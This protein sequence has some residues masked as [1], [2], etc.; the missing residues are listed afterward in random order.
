M[1]ETLS[2][3]LLEDDPVTI[4]LVSK[5]LHTDFLFQVKN[6]HDR[7]SFIEALRT[8]KYDC[9]I[10]DYILPDIDGVAALKFVAELSP[11]TPALI[12]TGS[13]GEEKVVEC[14]KAGA[15]D[16]VFKSRPHQLFPAIISAVKYRRLIEERVLAE[17]A[18]HESERRYQ[19][20]TEMSPVGIFRTDCKGNTTYVNPRW[21]EISGL[22]ADKAMG[23][24]W[25]AVV[26]PD[27]RSGVTS[28]WDMAIQ[29]RTV[30]SKKYRFL[31]PDGKI[32]WVLGYAIPEHNSQ[33]ELIGYV[34]TITDITELT[35]SEEQARK[36]SRAIE[37]GPSLVI[38]T[39]VSGEIEYVNPKF[40]EVTQYRS[41]EVLGKN[42]RFLKSGKTP[43]SQYAEL[44]NTLLSKKEWHGEF[45]N[46]KKN[47]ELYWESVMIAPIIN[48]RGAITHFVA[49]KENITA[50]KKSEETVQ[51]LSHTV[52][53]IG[54]CVSIT[55][56]H[57][58][59][60]YANKAFLTTYGYTEEEVL[61]K[62]I[63]MVGVY[64]AIDDKDVL[65]ATLQ[66]G[67]QGE[68]INRKK[69]G[70]EFPIALSSSAVYDE[71]GNAIA[72]VGVATDITEQK[73]LQEQLFQSQK[74]EA[75]GR[76]A[77]GVAHDYNNMLSII[78]GY[79][80]M[81]KTDMPL[82]EPASQKVDSIIEAA[83][84]SVNLTKQL[85]SF[86]RKQIVMPVL[87]NLNEEVTL[88]HKMLEHLIGED[89]SLNLHLASDLWKIKMDPVQITQILTNLATNAR[90]AITNVGTIIIA[91]SN[92]VVDTRMMMDG[93]DIPVGEYV[94]LTFSDSGTGMTHKTMEKIFEPFFTTKPMGQGTGLGLSTV[95]GIMKQNNGYIHTYS[96]LGH[97]TTFK[98]YFPRCQEEETISLEEKKAI[99]LNGTETILVVE[100]E[101]D[102]IHFV[103]V[104]LEDYGYKVLSVVSP[105]DALTLC[106]EHQQHIDLLITDVIMP[107]M[108]GKELTDHV[109][110]LYPQIKTL[111]MSGYTADIIARRGILDDD[112]EFLQKPFTPQALAQK[113][114]ILLDHT[115]ND[116]L[117]N[118]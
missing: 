84:R 51:L 16:F 76:L 7:L 12:Y 11:R 38:I 88:L 23:N 118:Q 97:G 56:L 108:N 27:D 95:F 10:I 44:W 87:L 30:S 75:I 6:V 46:K 15:A 3:L 26:H 115:P 70:T 90:D 34:G 73:K 96:E 92:I 2:I 86:A 71:T 91:I 109:Q 18:V 29:E 80:R 25:L 93:S 24:G 43:A 110:S 1:K 106:Q 20:L 52:E 55:D 21:C 116:K 117:R 83:E 35:Q 41:E 49:V 61:G 101:P 74:M 67:W 89:I 8:E 9:I 112:I 57:N 45:Q 63:K 111:Y 99:P 72:L 69:D 100:D 53:S 4:A 37:Q 59:I 22:E 31:R 79:A 105:L 68:L 62:H 48:E 28:G 47:G 114:R 85:L 66:G 82:T 5:L 77:G 103:T 42:P 102:L 60:L 65:A 78:L 64:T 33:G 50:R 13:V 104:A 36:L 113:V 54:E 19:T 14:M 107:E 17:N 94:L 58:H 81:L 32:S 98:L 40:E 39:N